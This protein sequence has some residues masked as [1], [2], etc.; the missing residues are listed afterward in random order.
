MS[1]RVWID[2]EMA[3]KTGKP[4][5]RNAK[6]KHLSAAAIERHKAKRASMEKVAAARGKLY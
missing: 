2:N 5:V 4:T 3:K 6:S 1:L